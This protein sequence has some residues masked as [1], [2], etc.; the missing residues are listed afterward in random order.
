M[1]DLELP[2]T[3]HVSWP[4]PPGRARGTFKIQGLT[5]AFRQFATFT[6]IIRSRMF[7]VIRW[8][9]ASSRKALRGGC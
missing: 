4:D 7:F 8:M 9:R 1:N 5:P 6:A 2:A 3:V